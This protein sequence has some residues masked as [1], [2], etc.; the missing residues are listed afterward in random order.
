MGAAFDAPAA[1]QTKI[2][3]FNDKARDCMLSLTFYFGVC[4]DLPRAVRGALIPPPC[5]QAEFNTPYEYRASP[6]PNFIP[7][8]N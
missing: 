1:Q 3:A 7:L 4:P 2:T 5:K 8:D 6:G